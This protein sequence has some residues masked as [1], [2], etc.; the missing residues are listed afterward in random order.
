M[1]AIEERSLDQL[2]DM[3]LNVL[4]QDLLEVWGV[5]RRKMDTEGVEAIKAA[6]SGA[7]D[8]F[9]EG[10]FKDHIEV[11]W[12]MNLCVHCNDDNI[13]K[14]GIAYVQ[15]SG[16][17]LEFN[18]CLNCRIGILYGL[19]TARATMDTYTISLG[20]PRQFGDFSIF[21]NAILP[22]GLKKFSPSYEVVKAGQWI[23]TISIKD[24]YSLTYLPFDSMQESIARSSDEPWTEEIPDELRSVME[25]FI[26]V[27][28]PHVEVVLAIK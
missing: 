8:R 13:E 21:W 17:G 16:D 14:N 4:S 1:S 18:Q 22:D 3:I 10:P 19:V 24:D 11:R 7:V 2:A 12:G 23:G 5:I 15:S 20:K 27:A 25:Q 28:K 26:E 6:F 9:L